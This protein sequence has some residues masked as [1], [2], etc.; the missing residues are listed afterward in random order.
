MS[1]ARETLERVERA[2][3]ATLK[4]AV[5]WEALTPGDITELHVALADLRALREASVSGRAWFVQ[6]IAKVGFYP[7]VTINY[8]TVAVVEDRPAL[9]IVEGRI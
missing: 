4:M 1:S 9:L 2:M 5:S 8:N 3:E 6:G 7:D